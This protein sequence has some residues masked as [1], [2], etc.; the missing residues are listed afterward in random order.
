MHRLRTIS[1]NFALSVFQA[2]GKEGFS[3]HAPPLRP[4]QL[5][6][7]S[8]LEVLVLLL[9]HQ[10]P[11]LISKRM[12]TRYDMLKREPYDSITERRLPQC[13]LVPAPDELHILIRNEEARTTCE[14]LHHKLLQV[15]GIGIEMKEATCEGS[16]DAFF[17]A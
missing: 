12:R 1:S 9:F 5:I 7:D 4:L 11:H 17:D 3:S 14:V 15:F 8:S 6:P 2:L 13:L 16:S 10:P